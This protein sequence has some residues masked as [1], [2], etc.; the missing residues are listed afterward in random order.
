MNTRYL[1][2][3]LQLLLLDISAHILNLRD[4]QQTPPSPTSPPTLASAQLKDNPSCL[5]LGEALAICGSL[6]S[7]FKDLDPSSQAHCLCYSSTAWAPSL[8]DSAV[9]SCAAF[10][11]ESATSAYSALANIEGFCTGIGDV[12]RPASNVATTT[13]ALATTTPAVVLSACGAMRSLEGGC[14]VASPGFAMMD[15]WAKARCLCYS[16]AGSWA[17]AVFDDA[18]DAC[19]R[20]ARTAAP[21]TFATVAAWEGFCGNMGDVIH[22]SAGLVLTPALTGSLVTSSG[23]LSPVPSETSPIGIPTT[24]PD[25]SILSEITVIPVPIP[26]PTP[27]PSPTSSPPSNSDSNLPTSILVA[28]SSPSTHTTL[29]TPTHKPTSNTKSNAQSQNFS[30]AAGSQTIPEVPRVEVIVVSL[31]C[32]SVLFFLC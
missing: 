1:F 11:S 29:T 6:T 12:A 9:K 25:P 28:S 15:N 5:I 10:A 20:V 7:N 24:S 32:A 30:T 3:T 18:V 31:V 4:D 23:L 26:T 13:W 21:G 8:F 27:I 2:L 16:P 14:A 19:N 17:P 22:G